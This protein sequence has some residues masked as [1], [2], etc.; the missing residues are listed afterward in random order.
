MYQEIDQLQNVVQNFL[1]RHLRKSCLCSGF[2]HFGGIEIVNQALSSLDENSP[3]SVL[4]LDFDYLCWSPQHFRQNWSTILSLV[5]SEQNTPLETLSQWQESSQKG[6]DEQLIE[7]AFSALQTAARHQNRKIVLILSQI[8]RL[9]TFFH[10]GGYQTSYKQMLHSINESDNLLFIM[11]GRPAARNEKYY[12]EFLDS[13]APSMI[14]LQPM[15]APEL[16]KWINQKGYSFSQ[17]V[18]EYI[19]YWTGGVWAYLPFLECY[20]PLLGRTTTSDYRS[21]LNQIMLDLANPTLAL[22]QYCVNRYYLSI[23]QAKGFGSLRTILSVLSQNAEMNLTQVSKQIGKSP[24]ATKDYLDSLREVGLIVR[25]KKNYR[26]AEPFLSRWLIVREN[27]W[28]NNRL[29]TLKEEGAVFPPA[30]KPKKPV[31]RVKKRDRQS[32][33]QDDTFLEFD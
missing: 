26:I 33:W 28:S 13:L 7:A 27:I 20:F 12:Q 29:G 24:P 22:H 25:E 15:T 2:D 32:E 9:Q 21:T 23:E 11:L 10:Y 17:A 30:A 4:K 14:D 6:A 5:L 1:T 8:H 3:R 16:E 19:H 18:Y 31:S